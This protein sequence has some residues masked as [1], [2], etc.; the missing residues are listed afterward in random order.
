MAPGAGCRDVCEGMP[1]P[2]QVLIINPNT[3]DSVSQLLHTL[4]VR[5]LGPEVAV[6]VQTA[7]LGASYI[8]D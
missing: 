1:V 8:S 2:V 5:E 6:R 3:S 4:A 7:R